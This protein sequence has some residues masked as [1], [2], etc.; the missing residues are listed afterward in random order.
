[1]EISDT[2][3]LTMEGT[4]GA[5]IPPTLQDMEHTPKPAFL[6]P[7]K[8]QFESTLLNSINTFRRNTVC[9]NY[10][11]CDWTGVT[12]PDNCW[13]ELRRVDIGDVKCCADHQFSYKCQRRNTQQVSCKQRKS[14][15][16]IS[17]WGFNFEGHEN[18]VGSCGREGLIKVIPDS[19]HV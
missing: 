4:N 6:K 19:E 7:W 9:G 2:A 10:T 18:S 5:R 8:K 17:Y 12:S 16:G 13:I 14:P 3:P 11:Q 15:K 1:M